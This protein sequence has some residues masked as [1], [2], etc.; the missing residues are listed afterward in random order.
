MRPVYL[1]LSG[2]ANAVT[3]WVPVDYLQ[4]AFNIGLLFSIS[5]GASL[6]ATVQ[7]TDDDINQDGHYVTATQTTTVITVTDLGPTLAQGNYNG[8]GTHGL[9]VGDWVKLEST[10][11]QPTA[12]AAVNT[13]D[14]EY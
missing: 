4:T 13:M 7:L 8:A 3:P 5:S 12:V 2:A 1:T 6:T 11:I 10:N 14:G 9:S